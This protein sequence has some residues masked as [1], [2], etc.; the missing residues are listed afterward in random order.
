LGY[1]ILL[2]KN[3]S[4]IEAGFLFGRE[5]LYRERKTVTAGKVGRYI[6]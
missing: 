1:L 5:D 6:G 2:L 3:L 4:K